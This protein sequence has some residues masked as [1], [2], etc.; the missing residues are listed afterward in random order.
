MA[1]RFAPNENSGRRESGSGDDY[2]RRLE[3]RLRFERRI[4]E[5]STRLINAPEERLD[6]LIEEGLGGIG[7]L[8]DVDRAYL[9]RFNTDHRLHS[10]THEWVAEG[11]TREAANLQEVPV[12]RFPWLMAELFAGRSVHVPKVT[13]LPDEASAEREEFLREGIRS[14]ALVPFGDKGAPSGFIGFDAVRS[15]HSWSDEIMLGLELLG[16]TFHNAF[17]AQAMAAELQRLALHDDL[18]GLANRKLL[19]D[20]LS[21]TIARYRRSG[22]RAA[23]MLID[24]DDFKLVNDSFGH[25]MGDEFLRAIAARLRNIVRDVDTVARLGG[26]EFVVVVEIADA[27]AI[28][29]MVARLVES[30]RVPVMLGGEAVVPAASIGIAMFPDDGGDAELLLRRADSAMYDAKAE[31]KNRSRMFSHESS[32]DSRDALRLRQQLRKGIAHGEVVP[33]YQPRVCLRSGRILG[34]E[35]LARWR[36]PQLGLLQPS[37]FLPL[38]ALIGVDSDLDLAMLDAALAQLAVWRESHPLLRVSVNISARNLTDEAVQKR[39]GQRL[40]EAGR[41]VAGIELEITESAVIRDLDQA[42]AS[43]QRLRDACPGLQLSLDDFG[44]GYSSLNYLRRLPLTTLKIDQCFV[45]DLESDRTG[46]T[47]AIVRSIIDLGRNL[48]LHIVAEGIE[49]ELQGSGLLALGCSEGQGF[50]F[51][52][53]VT[54]AEA[55]ELLK[56]PPLP[57]SSSVG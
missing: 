57:K 52:P 38:A 9:F 54:A 32:A 16:Q 27:E 23:V 53:P 11:V 2:R 19:R 46:S 18:T 12:C 20:R 34:F 4:A 44:S 24:I 49:T 28:E 14:L 35:A 56:A 45:I 25:S 55:T 13:D 22:I 21:Q 30:L 51:S 26:D 42:Q 10:N 47:H 6:A 40:R 17:R 3:L 8:F 43:L 1:D 29:P 7:T 37:H 48:G 5:L 50:Y 39:L 15:E 41:L 33:F 31:G 36:H